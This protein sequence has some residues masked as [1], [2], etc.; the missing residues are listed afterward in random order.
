MS[1]EY[2]FSPLAKMQL[3]ALWDYGYHH[4]G[5]QQADD[6]LDGLFSAI[7]EV[8]S[9]GHYL[10]LSPS[11]VPPDKI[12][13]IT[14]HSIHYIRYRQEFIYC[15]QLSDGALGVICILGG[16]MDTPRRRQEHL[17]SKSADIK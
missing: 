13:D 2:R 11:R 8:A 14:S 5:E 15:R 9:T 16:R 10:G 12:A 3:D 6:Y 7:A 4:F 17:S 1:D